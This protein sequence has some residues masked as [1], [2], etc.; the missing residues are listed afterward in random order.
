MNVLLLGVV[1]IITIG[2]IYLYD[3]DRRYLTNN[4]IIPRN[5]LKNIGES[6]VGAGV[7]ML[8]FDASKSRN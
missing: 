5:L 8:L 3:T 2:L 7:I 1:V 6:M 4:K